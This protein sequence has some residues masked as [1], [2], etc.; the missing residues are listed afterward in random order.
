MEFSCN[1]L[2][3]VA[4][5][6]VLPLHRRTLIYIDSEYA[7][8]KLKTINCINVSDCPLQHFEPPA[9]NLI[10]LEINYVALRLL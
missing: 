5:R 3:Y 10:I 8:C 7:K 9:L 1:L 4:I 6:R 2:S